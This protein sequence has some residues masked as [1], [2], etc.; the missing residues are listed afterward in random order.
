MAE[1]KHTPGPWTAAL[2]YS[3]LDCKGALIE[4]TLYDEDEREIAYLNFE[5][6]P[7]FDVMKRANARLIAAAPDLLEASKPTLSERART[8]LEEYAEAII[9]M[10]SGAEVGEAI[11][12]LLHRE[13]AI[14]AAIAKA[15]G[16]DS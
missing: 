12:F 14:R 8:R 16:R 5:D 2:S 6:S 9:A 13:T 7:H 15:E 1:S 4:G 3:E 10:E 11:Q